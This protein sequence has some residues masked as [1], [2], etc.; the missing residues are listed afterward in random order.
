MARLYD[1]RPHGTTAPTIDHA[2]GRCAV[3]RTSRSTGPST[4]PTAAAVAVTVVTVACVVRVFLLVA[5]RIDAAEV[6]REMVTTGP[7]FG[8]VVDMAAVVLIG[9]AALRLFVAVGPERVVRA[10]GRV[11]SVPGRLVERVLDVVAGGLLAARARV[12]LDRYGLLPGIYRGV[13][14]RRV[15][16]VAVD[17][18]G[19]AVRPA[20]GPTCS[21]VWC[22]EQA[23][24]GTVVEPFRDVAVAGVRLASLD[25]P[26]GRRYCPYH[27]PRETWPTPDVERYALLGTPA[28]ASTGVD[29]YDSDADD[30]ADDGGLPTLVDADGDVFDSA[31]ATLRFTAIGLL[32]LFTVA[33]MSTVQAALPDAGGGDGG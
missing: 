1:P 14:Y 16:D 18:D 29:P 22:D 27:S 25:A 19:A 21:T 17:E 28:V 30:G 2:A 20:D 24:V 32:V 15:E 10:V 7:S 5:D 26:D 31:A 12:D 3:R 4:R 33:V 23:A 8:M 6:E 11:L 9:A 13:G